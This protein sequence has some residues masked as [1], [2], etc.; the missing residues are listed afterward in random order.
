MANK[1]YINIHCAQ[2]K[3]MKIYPSKRISFDLIDS[4]QKTLERLRRRTEHSENLTSQL[5]DKSFRGKIK[6]N[7]FQ[8]ISSTPGF[9]A[10]CKLTGEIDAQ[11][12]TVKA[13]IHKAFKIMLGILYLLPLIGVISE[14]FTTKNGFAPIMILVALL[15]ILMIRLLFVGLVAFRFLSRFSLNKLRDVLDVKFKNHP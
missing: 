4:Q 15:Q 8:L 2:L 1:A 10:F 12:G 7:Q 3:Q 11:S 6:V 9:G 13:E 5:T 14:I